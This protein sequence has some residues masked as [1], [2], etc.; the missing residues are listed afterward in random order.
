MMSRNVRKHVFMLDCCEICYTV[1]E[2][3]DICQM[4]NLPVLVCRPC[5]H[6]HQKVLHPIMVERS[7]ALAA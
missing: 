2:Q 4:R 7:D 5:Q 1:T 3:W 6:M